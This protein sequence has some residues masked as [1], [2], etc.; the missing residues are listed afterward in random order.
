MKFVGGFDKIGEEL[1][2]G[3]GWRGSALSSGA[4]EAL[5]GSWLHDARQRIAGRWAEID[6]AKQSQQVEDQPRWKVA[7]IAV[8][9]RNSWHFTIIAVW[10][11]EKL[12]YERYLKEEAEK[13]ARYFEQK[14]GLVNVYD[15]DS[16]YDPGVRTEMNERVGPLKYSKKRKGKG[17]ESPRG[18]RASQTMKSWK[19]FRI[20]EFADKTGYDTGDSRYFSDRYTSD[21]TI[22]KGRRSPKL[23]LSSRTPASGVETTEAETTDVDSRRGTS[24]SGVGVGNHLQ[25]FISLIHSL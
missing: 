22:G 9:F 5:A 24:L 7:E 12:G 4:D 21:V 3:N 8:V 1:T 25:S 16:K 11:D 13:R 6:C 2:S 23:R 19:S 17:Y 10:S 14:S 20:R 15:T 18:L